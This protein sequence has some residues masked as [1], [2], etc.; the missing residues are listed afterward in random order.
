MKNFSILF[1]IIISHFSFGQNKVVKIENLSLKEMDNFDGY[2]AIDSLLKN[3]KYV[4]LGESAHS[5][6]EFIIARHKL[7]NYLHE[8]H[9]FNKV[10]FE[11][12]I[13]DCYY[14]NKHKDEKDSLWLM[15]HS[16]YGIWFSKSTLL[17]L[18]D[19]KKDNISIGGFDF[20]SSSRDQASSRFILELKNIDTSLLSE[21]FKWDKFLMNLILPEKVDSNKLR[22]L[23]D[24]LAICR[25]ILNKNYN[26]ID[27][28][29]KN[30]QM[31]NI[32]DRYVSRIILNKLFFL[33]VC[34]DRKKW[35]AFRDSVMSSNMQWFCDSLFP[36]EKIIF[37][38]ANDHIAREKSTFSSNYFAGAVLP[39]R[40]K[41]QSYYIGLYALSGEI[42]SW[43]SGK[44]AMGKLNKS[45]L[46]VR[47]DNYF[48]SDN[49]VFLDFSVASKQKDFRWLNKKTISYV[50]G[51]IP[52]KIV[53][54]KNYDGMILINKLSVIH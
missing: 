30:K 38:G 20:Q 41:S 33:S 48:K 2:V 50:W 36:N 22:V 53:P 17:M 54:A 21:T 29:Y 11:S 35:L 42:Y 12:G 4:F 28:I 8:K 46:E 9:G 23:N 27:S 10:I 15:T 5:A 3:K 34:D 51:N 44:F 37:W 40:I 24:S 1:L 7:I 43:K 6:E 39:E 18:N 31:K 19:F 52:V 45:S 25:N 16:I 14:G 26:Y 49:D 13:S 32:D 47:M